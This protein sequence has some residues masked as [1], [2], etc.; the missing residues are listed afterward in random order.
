[1][2]NNPKSYYKLIDGSWDIDILNDYMFSYFILTPIPSDHPRHGEL[3]E[4]GIAYTCTCPQFNH[5]FVCKHAI[6][7]SL[8]MGAVKLP[9]KLNMAHTGKRKAPAGAKASKRGNCLDCDA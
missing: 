7:V 4:A 5:Y 1:M 3:L 8:H 6:M 2:V 9:D